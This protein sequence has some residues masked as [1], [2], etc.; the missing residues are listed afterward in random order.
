M[1]D[2]GVVHLVGAG[3]GDPE[4]LTVKARR[5]VDQA[6][7]VLHDSLVG[8]GVL[9][10]VPSD[11]RVL[12]V[13]KRPDDGR[14]WEQDEINRAMAGLALEGND[15]VRL[16]GGDPTTF[17]RGGEEA[18]YLAERNVPFEIVPGV[19]SVNT[20]PVLAGIPLTH[21]DHASSLTVVTGYEDPTK[22]DS[23]IDWEALAGTVT[24]GGT[25]VILMGVTQMAD[26]MAALAAAGV[27]SETPAAVVEHVNRPDQAVTV[28]TV[29]TIADRCEAADVTPPAVTI[30]GDVV[31]VREDVREAFV[32]PI[33]ET[34]SGAADGP[35]VTAGAGDARL[36]ADAG[37]ELQPND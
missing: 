29:D 22:P 1:T 15:V 5:L 9:A 16:K 25:L 11:V 20:A 14:R 37:T 13:G 4:L 6:D 24:T 19:S 3:P 36:N 18:C 32:D 8:D 31:T 30:V 35:A 12:S 21:R 23:A 26:N 7:V 17:G 2:T 33:P 34:V 27:P 10:S 28:G